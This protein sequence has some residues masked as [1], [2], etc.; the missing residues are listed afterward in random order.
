MNSNFL[1]FFCEWFGKCQDAWRSTRVLAIRPDR[2]WRDEHRTGQAR[3][4]SIS[5]QRLWL[6]LNEVTSP[7]ANCERRSDERVKLVGN[8]IPRGQSYTNVNCLPMMVYEAHDSDGRAWRRML[9]RT[10]IRHFLTNTHR[11]A[12][13]TRRDSVARGRFISKSRL[14]RF[15]ATDLFVPLR[16]ALKLKRSRVVPG[17]L[18]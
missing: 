4:S 13:E 2:N 1:R 18:I 17:W 15:E 8:A 7:W 5:S 12:F 3:A 6:S 9:V 11:V 14:I 10:W 16:S